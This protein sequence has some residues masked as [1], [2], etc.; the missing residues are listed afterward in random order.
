MEKLDWKVGFFVRPKTLDSRVQIQISFMATLSIGF[1]QSCRKRDL[2]SNLDY[3]MGAHLE[4]LE[5]ELWI[6]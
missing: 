4:A 1:G 6:P 5:K 3:H 2:D